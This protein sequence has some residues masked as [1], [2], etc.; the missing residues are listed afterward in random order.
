MGNE[1]KRKRKRKIT[2]PYCLTHLV[3]LREE[4]D[5]DGEREEGEV[6]GGERVEIGRR[7]RRGRRT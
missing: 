5:E 6:I 4:I 7:R 2:N 3:P 1:E